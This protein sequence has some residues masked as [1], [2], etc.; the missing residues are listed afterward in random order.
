M[1]SD[2]VNATTSTGARRSR[3]E[4]ELR[5]RVAKRFL[6]GDYRFTRNREALVATLAAADR[7]LTIPEIGVAA[8]TLAVSSIYRNVAMLEALGIVQGVVTASD[9]AHYELAEDLTENH[10]HHLV[11]SSCGA[12]EDFVAPAQLEDSVRAA[13]RRVGRK[14]RFRVE[15]HS[16]DF[17]GLCPN[18]I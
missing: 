4:P 8:R 7:P 9:F 18:C 11:C 3:L 16:V 12:V 10:H 15:R 6:E 2:E 17:I 14:S 1:G 5:A 13:A